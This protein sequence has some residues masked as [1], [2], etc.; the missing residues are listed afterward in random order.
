MHNRIHTWISTFKD[1]GSFAK[2]ITQEGSPEAAETYGARSDADKAH[3]E[4][5]AH[6]R[7]RGLY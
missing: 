4:F 5:P 7:T 3:Q 6:R 2:H 1:R